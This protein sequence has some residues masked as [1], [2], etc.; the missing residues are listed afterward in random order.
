LA[1]AG[2]LSSACFVAAGHHLKQQ[3]WWPQLPHG[4]QSKGIGCPS[5]QG[6]IGATGATG[7]IVPIAM[8]DRV[9]VC[10]CVD[11]GRGARAWGMFIPCVLIEKVGECQM[12]VR[13]KGVTYLFDY[14][15]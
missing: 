9:C 6:G 14:F 4:V 2:D 11:A 13:I 10:V 8:I 5:W 3:Q 7:S 12:E 15:D 1:V